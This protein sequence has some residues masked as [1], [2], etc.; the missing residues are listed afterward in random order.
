MHE[1]LIPD[2]APNGFCPGLT[3]G[4]PLPPGTRSC[5]TIYVKEVQRDK[6]KREISEMVTER[7]CLVGSR[8]QRAEVNHPKANLSIHDRDISQR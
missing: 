2:T 7:Y 1:R 6:L 3:N 5:A 4:W 8:D